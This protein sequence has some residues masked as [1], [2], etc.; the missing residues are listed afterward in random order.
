[1]S[2][3]WN[4][5]PHADPPIWDQYFVRDRYTGRRIARTE[6]KL[7]SG[8]WHYTDIDTVSFDVS[9]WF[10]IPNNDGTFRRVILVD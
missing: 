5:G 3:T 9:E 8:G 7:A 1:M 4:I 2:E 10:H 6:Q